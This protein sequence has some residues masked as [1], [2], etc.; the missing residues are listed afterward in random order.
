MAALIAKTG[1][2]LALFAVLCAP[3]GRS[4]LAQTTAPQPQPTTP[5]T[6]P[7]TVENLLDKKWCWRTPTR[8]FE[9]KF[10]RNSLGHHYFEIKNRI[11]SDLR[12]I[13]TNVG[14]WSFDPET[15][16]LRSQLTLPN[17]SLDLRKADIWKVSMSPDQK[18][19]YVQQKGEGKLYPMLRCEGGRILP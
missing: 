2:V 11:L 6:I 5:P 18:I 14:V 16:I 17:A 1:T 19:L 7:V 15:S 8:M 13:V 3:V 9:W 10:S 12:D 4:A